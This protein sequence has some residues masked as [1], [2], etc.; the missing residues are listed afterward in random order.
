[1]L[2]EDYVMRLINELVRAVLKLVFHIDTDSPAAEVLQDAG[3][4]E[5]LE[6]LKRMADRGEIGA[7]ENRIYD[8]TEEGG[9]ENLQIALL[10]YSYLN[11]KDDDFLEAHDFSREEVRDGL[12]A[13]VSAYGY[14][15]MAEVFLPE[16]D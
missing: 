8:L 15:D 12:K 3:Q 9:R 11:E 7:A 14:G 4:Q 5:I 2:K 13:A 16:E 10:F 1:M 6:E